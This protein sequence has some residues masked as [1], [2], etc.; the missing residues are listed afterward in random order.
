MKHLER[1]SSLQVDIVARHLRSQIVTL[2]NV[3]EAIERVKDCEED[4]IK[5]SLRLVEIEI[6]RLR[7]LI[8]N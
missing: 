1:Q 8:D 2:H 7:S 4:Y 3:L 6:R 5:E